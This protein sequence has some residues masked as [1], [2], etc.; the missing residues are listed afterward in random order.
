MVYHQIKNIPNP[1]WS[2][3]SPVIAWNAFST[4]HFYKPFAPQ[5]A[6]QLA[7]LTTAV[8]DALNTQKSTL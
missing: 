3:S 4:S 6:H 7:E 5:G 2:H 1:F 8:H